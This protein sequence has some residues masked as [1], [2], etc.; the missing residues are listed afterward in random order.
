[1]SRYFCLDSA[2]SRNWLGIWL[3]C[4]MFWGAPAMAQDGGDV[5]GLAALVD[6]VEQPTIQG[7]LDVPDTLTV[8]RATIKPQPGAKLFLLAVQG[9]PVGYLLDGKASWTYRVEDRFSV[10][11]SRSNLKLADGMRVQEASGLLTV[12]T[13]LR[14]MAVW[15]WDTALANEPTE[16]AT[17]LELPD[18]LRKTLESKLTAN[19]GRDLLLTAKNGGPGY[20]WAV[21]EGT[22]ETLTLEVDPRPTAR[23]EQVSRLL[24]IRAGRS[25]GPYTGRRASERLITQPIERPWWEAESHDFAA[26]ETDIAVHNAKG[27]HVRVTTKTRLQ[28]LRDGLRVIPMT[29][30]A[31]DFDSSGD[32]HDYNLQRL[33]LNGQEATFLRQESNL[34]VELPRR[35][36]AGDVFEL[37][38]VAE[39]QILRRPSGDNYWRLG[40]NSWYVKPGYGG[41]EWAEIR[42]A[43]DVA[44]PFVPFA[45][46]EV[47]GQGERDGLNYI[48]TRQEAPMEFAMVVAGKYKT[49]TEKN[50]AAKVHISSYGT[51]KGEAARRIGQ[52]ILSVQECMGSWLGVDYPFPDLQVVEVKQW[53]WGQAPPGII[54]ITQEA[55]LTRASAKVNQE[56]TLFSAFTSRGINARVA[57]EVAH[58]WFPHVAK[59]T[60][61][62]EN[63]LSESLSDYTSAVCL[64]QK[65]ANK[66]KGKQLFDRNLIEWRRLSKEAGDTSSVYLA[67]HL[68][69][70]TGDHFSARRA[71]WYGRGPLVLHSIRLQLQE[72]HGEA[73]GDNMFFGWLRAYIGN[74]TNKK[75]ET[76]HLITILNQISGE[77]WTPFFERHIYGAEPPEV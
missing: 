52:V 19:P 69:G 18:W 11:P 49:V 28:V 71:L 1:M 44:P 70:G 29:L 74:F 56:S 22:G 26:V 64:E 10:P 46:G 60:R 30:S 39:G 2:K 21:F 32:W 62:E 41:Q 6:A 43:A 38:V 23:Q 53:G 16:P 40:G 35:A 13:E 55:F 8:G 3:C 58:A 15:G 59:V 24:K 67:S 4:V 14:G 63:W 48:E 7:R 25:V 75:A 31:G 66:K 20:R 12:T 45:G 37:E 51:A 42:I 54:F 5:N 68:S 47:L 36:A 50:D 27:N 61:W 73:K 72:K 76:R 57:H 9:N 77:D 34:L 65:M 17:E 33:S